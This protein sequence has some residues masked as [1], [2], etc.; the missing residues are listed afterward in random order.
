MTTTLRYKQFMIIPNDY[1]KDVLPNA[2][3]YIRVSLA[4]I[5]KDI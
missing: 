2:L 1:L 3:N 5:E 4:S